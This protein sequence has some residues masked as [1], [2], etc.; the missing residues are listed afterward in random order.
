ML[1]QNDKMIRDKLIKTKYQQYFLKEK[2]YACIHVFI[3]IQR[4]HIN[5]IALNKIIRL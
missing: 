1:C 2:L 4:S 3:D 5:D